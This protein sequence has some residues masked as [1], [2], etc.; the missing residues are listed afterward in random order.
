MGFALNQTIENYEV[1]G[2]IDKPRAGVTY[3]VR[4]L[5]TGVLEAL[6]VLPG[7]TASDP[8]STE[9]LLREIRVHARLLHPN[10]VTFHHAQEVDGNLLM[11]TEFVEGHSLAELCSQGPLPRAEAVRSIAAVLGG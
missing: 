1:L 11:T 5:T 7:A 9:R 6:R 3:K 10:I 2:I 4:N 8:E